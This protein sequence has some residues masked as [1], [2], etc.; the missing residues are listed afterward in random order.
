MSKVEPD[1]L[2]KIDQLHKERDDIERRMAENNRRIGELLQERDALK[3][4]Y[5]WIND[6]IQRIER[7]AGT[8]ETPGDRRPTRRNINLLRAWTVI[9]D[10]LAKNEDQ[11]G[12]H[13]RD[14]RIAVAR[15]LPDL[16]DATFR[17][18]LHRFRKDGVI[19]KR[20]SGKWMLTTDRDKRGGVV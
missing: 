12:V 9:Q 4:Q 8:V 19:E 1:H 15:V 7:D 16:K 6:L 14:L 13:Q 3:K 11:G 10:R 2:V 18:Y 20:S 5:F 17:S